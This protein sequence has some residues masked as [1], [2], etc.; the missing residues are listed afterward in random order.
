MLLKRH[1][2]LYTIA[3]PFELK[4]R[5]WSWYQRALRGQLIPLLQDQLL[6]PSFQAAIRGRSGSSQISTMMNVPACQGSESKK[7]LSST[8]SFSSSALQISTPRKFHRFE[9]ITKG[10]TMI[11]ISRMLHPSK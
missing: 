7:T 9:P 3:D 2:D 1:L 4:T 5:F 6:K 8:M 11:L 10:I